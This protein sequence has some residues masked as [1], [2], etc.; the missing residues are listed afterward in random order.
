MRL[1]S[2]AYYTEPQVQEI[3]KA[4][5]CPVLCVIAD[6]GYIVA[7]EEMDSRLA[8]LKNKTVETIAGFH[9]LHMDSPEAVA[10]VINNFLS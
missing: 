2:P 9:H 6:D 4:V 1:A 3:L 8:M 7:R 10:N 5:Q